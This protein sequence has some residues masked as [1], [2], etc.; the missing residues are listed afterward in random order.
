LQ[1][2]EDVIKSIVRST[3]KTLTA[4]TTII[5]VMVVILL[6][7]VVFTGAGVKAQVAII[8]AFFLIELELNS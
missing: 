7:I 4:A 1:D 6:P 2:L 3:I 5:M 8:V